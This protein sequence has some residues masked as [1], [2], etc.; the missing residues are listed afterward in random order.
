MGNVFIYPMLD[1]SQPGPTALAVVVTA[2][3]II[4]VYLI[5]VGFTSLRD[6]LTRRIR[7]D[8]MSLDVSNIA[9]N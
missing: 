9:Y 5:V 6:V 4:I 8:S 7:R 1:W 3:V 2:I